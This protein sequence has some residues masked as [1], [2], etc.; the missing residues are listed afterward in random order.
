MRP[1]VSVGLLALL[2]AGGDPTAPAIAADGTAPVQKIAVDLRGPLALVEVTRPL[3]VE[4]PRHVSEELLDIGLPERAALLSVEVNERGRWQAVTAAPADRARIGYLEALQARGIAGKSEPFDDNTTCRLHVAR[5][6]GVGAS[7]PAT[8]VTVRYRFSVLT[9]YAH[10]RQRVRFPPSPEMTPMPADITVTGVALG[11]LEIAGVRTTLPA[12]A[13]ASAAPTRVTGHA[14]TRTGW[15]ISYTLVATPAAGGPGGA[16]LDGIAAAAATSDRES[17]IAFSVHARGE[18]TGPPPENVLFLIDRSRS[19][20]IAGLSAEHGVATR[21]LELLPPA[22]RFDV[23]FF[24]RAVTRLFPMVR[25]ATREAIAAI[26]PEMV[27]DRLANGT[28]LVGAFR[29]AGDLMRREASAFAPRTL[30]I[31]ITDGSISERQTGPLLDGALGTLSGID[32]TV[33][34]MVV[35]TG[36]D[37]VVPPSA[38][39]ALEAVAEARGGVERELRADDI[40]EGLAPII[41]VLAAGGDVFSARVATG[42]VSARLPG[43]VTPGSGISGVVR[44]GGKMRRAAELV[45]VTRGH[46]VRAPLKLLDVDPAWLRPHADGA[47]ASPPESRLLALPGLVA[48]VEPVIRAAPPAPAPPVR[49]AMDKDVVRNTLSLAFMPRA[50]ACYQSR[51]GSTAAMRDLTGRVRLAIDLVRGEVV[52]AHVESTTL[53]QPP[54]ETCLRESAFA[55]EVPRAYRNDQPV[56]AM[57]NMVFRPRTPEKTH[58]AED[59]FPIG[60]E[61]DLILEEL[62]KAEGAAAPR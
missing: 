47:S 57:V 32:V 7:P 33:A 28:D 36:D 31:L 1:A 38:R 30:L 20:G 18:G 21:L 6:G 16:P 26:E 34:L 59:T 11:D 56:T 58:T 9:E 62:K 53:N 48:M 40:S 8:P 39:R 46:T 60:G 49:G 45:G 29:A 24:D 13:A 55:L 50:R 61:I 35:S 2:L 44:M 37:D 15:E 23:L 3:S 27:P 10:G 12:R 4:R 22:T 14:S 52:D 41:P 51:P 54:I 43:T 42:G 25:P 5:G 17:A 19:V